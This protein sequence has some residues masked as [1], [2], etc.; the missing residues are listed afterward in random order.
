[1]YIRTQRIKALTPTP[2]PIPAYALVERDREDE[3]DMGVVVSVDGIVGGFYG[4][5]VL[6]DSEAAVVLS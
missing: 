6:L 5:Y 3:L 4:E 1:M 2:A